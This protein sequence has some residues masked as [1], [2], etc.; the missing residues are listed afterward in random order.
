MEHVKTHIARL[1]FPENGIQV[2]AI[3]VEQSARVVDQLSDRFNLSLKHRTC[4][5]IG[6]HDSSCS[7]TEFGLEIVNFD[8]AI[9]T[10]GYFNDVEATHC[11]CRWIRAMRGG[12]H[13]DLR[14][15][16][17]LRVHGGMRESLVP[18]AN[19]P[20]APRHGCQ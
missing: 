9:P 11:C 20:W 2:C 1:D 12:R 13:D 5:R 10:N 16:T 7:F 8:V 18:P 4:R 6:Q 19:S 17:V 3:V 15:L 14:S